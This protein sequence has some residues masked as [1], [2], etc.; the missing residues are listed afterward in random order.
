MIY[1][2]LYIMIFDAGRSINWASGRVLGPGNLEFFR[3]QMALAYRLNAISQG[4]K[5]SRYPG[6]NPLPLT[7]IVYLHA[8]KTLRMGPYKSKV[9]K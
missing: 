4:P 5:N 8:S 9:L 6:P 7:L 3:P 1:T 2:A